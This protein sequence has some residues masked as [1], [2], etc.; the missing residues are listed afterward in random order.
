MKRSARTL[1]VAMAAAPLFAHADDS[2]LTKQ[3]TACID[4]AGSTAAMLDCVGAETKTQDNSLNANYALLVK[5]VAP[6]RKTALQEAQR[7]WLKYRDANC[8]YYADP[9]GGSAAR[10]EGVSCVMRMTAERASELGGLAKD[11]AAR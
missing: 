4:R 9:D 11:A 2:L 7:A 10:V 1:A 8:G 5:R 3:Y 6:T